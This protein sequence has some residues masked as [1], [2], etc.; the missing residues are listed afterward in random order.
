MSA[1]EIGYLVLRGKRQDDDE[2]D[3]FYHCEVV[4]HPFVIVHSEGRTCSCVTLDLI[5]QDYRLHPIAAFQIRDLLLEHR[6]KTV[7][8]GCWPT[9][10]DPAVLVSGMVSKAQ[11]EPIARRMVQLASNPKF[12]VKWDDAM[13]KMMVAIRKN[14]TGTPK[15]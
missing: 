4:N 1:F 7:L 3:W 9:G 15:T 12:Q 2:R 6:A 10:N 8:L 11:A 5:G 14:T 13:M